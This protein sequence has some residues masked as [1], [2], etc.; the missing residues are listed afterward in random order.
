MPFNFF[1]R[2]V[3]RGAIFRTTRNDFRVSNSNPPPPFDDRFSS[4][5]RKS[6]SSQFRTFSPK[7]LFTPFQK[8]QVTQT[9]KIPGKNRRA[10]VSG[11]GAVFSEVDLEGKTYIDYF[12]KNNCLL[13]RVFIPPKN[14]G[15][16][17]GG[18][19]IIGGKP[20]IWKVFV[21]LGNVSVEVAGRR[22]YVF[23][24]GDI[25]VLDDIIYAEPQ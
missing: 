15:L 16:S 10:S 13:S 20:V 6:L 18:V 21:K 7:R 9:F 5:L 23:G 2:N 25:V 3:K 17:F 14:K 12:T 8:N 19:Y 11:F 1:E 24:S 22:D 4:L